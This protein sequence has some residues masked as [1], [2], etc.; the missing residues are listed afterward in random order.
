MGLIAAE[1]TRTT[2][3]L[4]KK[5]DISGKNIISYHDFN[6]E[7]RIDYI[8]DKL[9]TGHDIAL[10]SESGT[11]A[12]QDP[13]FKVIERCIEKNIPLT[14]IPGPNAAVSALVLSGLP[15]DSFLFVGFLP[16]SKGKRKTRILELAPVPSTIIFYESP[17]RVETLIC[18]LSEIFGD[19]R[20]SLSREITKIYEESIRGRLSDILKKIKHKKV[21]GEVVLV[22]EGYKKEPIK[23]YTEEDI[24]KE[25]FR[26]LK[27]G[28][29]KKSAIKIVLSR[30]DI[31]KQK[32]YNIATKI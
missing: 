7:S 20:A 4:L 15:T 2:K 25:L 3:K 17:K 22:V 19:R 13:G 10:V 18:E 16:R 31:D 11:P 9:E 32:L 29:S 21:K 8:M 27:Q 6:K 24:R 30:Y 28:I 1:D 26:L 12:I 5:Y 14:V 23:N